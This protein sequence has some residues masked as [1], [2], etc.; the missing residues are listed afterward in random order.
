MNI[1]KTFLSL[2]LFFLALNS[3]RFHYEVN[4]YNDSDIEPVSSIQTAKFDRALKEMV[5]A[6]NINTAGIGIIKDGVL[7]WEGYYGEQSPGVAA[8]ENTLFNTA[9][10]TKT[11]TTETILRLVADGRLSLDESMSDYWIDPDLKEDPRHHLLTPRMALNHST[12]FLNWR[13]FSEDGKLKFVNE[14]G[15]QFGYSGEG[16]EYLAKFA[17]MKLRTP[18]EDLVNEVL[19]Q[20]LE[21]NDTF[22]SVKKNNHNRIAKPVSS[23][24]E[25]YGFYCRPEGWCS[26]EGQVSVADDMVTTVKNYAQFLIAAMHGDGLNKTLKKQRIMINENLAPKKQIDCNLFPKA[27][28]PET[29][30]YGLGWYI[31]E[32]S[33]NQLVG[34]GGSD[35]SEISQAYYYS[36]SHDGVIIFLNAASKNALNG[37]LETLE[38]IDPKSALLHEY[39][40]WFLN[41]QK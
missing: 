35:W 2:L 38:I 30:G 11:I 21:M 18:F 19:F 4:W 24:G 17:E 15:S 20:P 32:P 31:N 1:L 16:F 22:I 3:C 39:N 41:S 33:G 9:S 28:C 36:G 7:V 26:P 27:E 40:R 23:T 6:H 14:P 37:M 25:F 12:G 10:I 13:F 34:H 5:K 29:Q 8:N